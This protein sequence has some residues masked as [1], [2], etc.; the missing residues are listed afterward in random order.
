MGVRGKALLQ[1]GQSRAPFSVFPL[2][3]WAAFWWIPSPFFPTALQSIPSYSCQICLWSIF[4][5]SMRLL[6]PLSPSPLEKWSVDISGPMSSMT[7]SQPD[8]PCHSCV[9]LSSST[10]T[11]STT[12]ACVHLFPSIWKTPFLQF[13]M[14]KSYPPSGSQY[15][16]MIFF[17]LYKTAVK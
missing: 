5:C 12:G 7:P 16:H 2:D 8:H 1:K 17:D 15:K 14:C 9:F 3:D 10:V 6:V 4:S 11:H 13:Y